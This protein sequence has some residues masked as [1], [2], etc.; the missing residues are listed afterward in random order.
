VSAVLAEREA[1]LVRTSSSA[2]VI[3]SYCRPGKGHGA[4][5]LLRLA[6]FQEQFI[7]DVYAPGV[8]TGAM[9]VARGNGK[10]TLEAAISLHALFDADPEGGAPQVP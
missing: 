5:E 10:S 1:H 2:F 3:T 8:R 9:S 6:P 7:R 4:G